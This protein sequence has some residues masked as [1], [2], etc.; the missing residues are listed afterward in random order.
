MCEDLLKL[1]KNQKQFNIGNIILNQ[2]DQ[3]FLISVSPIT[4]S[5]HS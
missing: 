5:L 2:Q 1:D 4:Q 3:N